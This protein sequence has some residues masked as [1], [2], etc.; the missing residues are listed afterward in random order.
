MLPPA[1][2]LG[3]AYDL[4][5]AEAVLHPSMFQKMSLFRD[6]STCCI[7]A[8]SCPNGIVP[9]GP[10]QTPH[11]HDVYGFYPFLGTLLLIDQ[12]DLI[13]GKTGCRHRLPAQLL[14]VILLLSPQITTLP[15]VSTFQF[16]EMTDFFDLAVETVHLD[17]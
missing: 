13:R 15:V 4:S 17:T 1:R 10:V 6:S 14:S 2:L 11:L 3:N 7:L 12:W 8:T 9:G 16:E 5:K